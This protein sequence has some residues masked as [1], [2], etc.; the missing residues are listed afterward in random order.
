[1]YA[2]DGSV[3]KSG[4]SVTEI[5]LALTSD[6][7]SCSRWCYI[8]RMSLH[9]TKTTGILFGSTQ[10][11]ARVDQGQFCPE[12]DGTKISIVDN[13]SLLGFVLDPSLTFKPHVT[14]LLS[15][16]NSGLYFIRTARDLNLPRRSRSLLY[17]SLMHSH[18]MYGISIYSSCTDSA[19]VNSVHLKRKA[20][21]RLVHGA[22]RLAHTE[23]LFAELNWPSFEN[24]VDISLINHIILAKSEH[25][26][27]YL[28]RFYPPDHNHATRFASSH[29]FSVPTARKTCLQ[30][31]TT[32]RAI[33]TWNRIPQAVRDSALSAPHN[34]QIAKL[35]ARKSYLSFSNVPVI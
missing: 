23:L 9:P 6:L 7:T 11:L 25:S 28:D 19:L 31:A 26:P 20:A 13:F 1:M 30:R 21:V 18:I 10:C 24:L 8:N 29:A 12:L 17:F 5:S 14:H 16:L 22:D 35:R 3:T 33:K 15:R 4:K 27:S 34:S 2:D 32:S